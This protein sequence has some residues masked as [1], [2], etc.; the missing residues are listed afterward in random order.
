[1]SSR[2]DLPRHTRVVTHA[3]R[4]HGVQGA[5]ARQPSCT[6]QRTPNRPSDLALPIASPQGGIA[7]AFPSPAAFAYHS[8]ATHGLLDT[9]SPLS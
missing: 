6:I 1:L 9:P 5:P 3:H 2:Q 8:A 4:D 7:R